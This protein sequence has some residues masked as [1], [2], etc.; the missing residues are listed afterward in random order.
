[1][2]WLDGLDNG[3]V[4]LFDASFFEP[5]TGGEPATSD[6]PEAATL[7][8][9]YTK[10]R[11][12]L[13]EMQRTLKVDPAHGFALPYTNRRTGDHAL[14]TIAA[15]LQLLPAGFTSEPCRSTDS[16]IF[17]IIEG[18]GLSV[19]GDKEF[20]WKPKDI[21]VAPSWTP[22]QHRTEGGAILFSFSDRAAQEKLSLWRE[23]RDRQPA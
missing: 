7:L 15:F 5:A 2:V 11:D 23:K 6:G 16:V 3:I 9:P 12:C 1:M 13:A 8:H 14:S 19:I 18:T 10:M 22:R 20:R 17:V 21:F 4:N